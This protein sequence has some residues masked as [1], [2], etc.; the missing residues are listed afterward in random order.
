MGENVAQKMEKPR[1]SGR[2]H[3]T[4][5]SPGNSPLEN[6]GLRNQTTAVST[7]PSMTSGYARGETLPH[8]QLLKCPCQPSRMFPELMS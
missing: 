8:S 5:T 3:G 1:R 6:W 4:L 2:R 7:A